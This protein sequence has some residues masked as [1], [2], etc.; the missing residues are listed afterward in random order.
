MV[1]G[2]G[3]SMTVGL[4]KRG[5]H[6]TREKVFKALCVSRHLILNSREERP[7]WKIFYTSF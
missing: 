4:T 1:V 6:S 7:A 2:G 5:G 3:G